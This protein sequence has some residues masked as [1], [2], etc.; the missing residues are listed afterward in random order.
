VVTVHVDGVGDAM[1]GRFRSGHFEGVATVVAKL[2][3]GL[4]PD[5]AYFGKK[6]AQQLAVV[7]NMATALRFPTTVVGLPT[8]RESDG[9]AL[10]S[11]NMR[12]GSDA[13]AVA[14]MLSKSLF[15]AA[16][17]IE[18][19]ERDSVPIIGAVGTILE[20]VPGLDVEYVEVADARTAR[21]VRRIEADAFVAVA[22]YI[23]GVRLI[24]NIAVDGTTLLVDRG[25][26]LTTPSVLYGRAH[27]ADD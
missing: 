6:D 24:D 27:A 8:V 22:A 21:P 13:R 1:E 17:L 9:L 15:F 2:F 7:R 11:R 10:S 20:A 16:D 5:R 19:G 26:V 14:S 23:G 18:A 12:L 4:A 3:A 25:S